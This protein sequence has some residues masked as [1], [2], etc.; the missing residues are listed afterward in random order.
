M[1][2]T[3]LIVATSVAL[4][5]PAAF[6]A[7]TIVSVDI[8]ETV[9]FG[10]AAT[11]NVFST[12]DELVNNTPATIVPNNLADTIELLRT[13]QTQGD[14]NTGAFVDI[15]N[16]SLFIRGF[17]GGVV[18]QSMQIVITDIQFSDP[19]YAIGNV[20]RVTDDLFPDSSIEQDQLTIDFTANSIT[21]NWTASAENSSGLLNTAPSYFEADE[22]ALTFVS[23]V[24]EPSSS[25]LLALS[26]VVML[27]RRKR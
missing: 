18:L 21:L 16:D 10:G 15:E 22:F 13:D 1:N 3:G 12:M 25:A 23:V 27:M 20:V 19:N 14:S 26:G 11:P 7:T 17:A 5:A 2:K 8:V 6:A 9:S 24:P 4:V